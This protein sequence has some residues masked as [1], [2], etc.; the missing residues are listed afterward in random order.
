MGSAVAKRNDEGEPFGGEIVRGCDEFD[1]RRGVDEKT[2]RFLAQDVDVVWTWP[3]LREV[4]IA[5]CLGDI[6]QPCLKEQFDI[7]V[8]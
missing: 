3:I 7:V 5:S 6:A 1:N 4:T 8:N 2:G